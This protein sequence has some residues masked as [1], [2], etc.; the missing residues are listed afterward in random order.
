MHHQVAEAL[1]SPPRHPIPTLDEFGV[2]A[3]VDRDQSGS[4]AYRTV[5]RGDGGINWSNRHLGYLGGALA[6][7]SSPRMFVGGVFYPT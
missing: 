5:Q 6:M 7:K 1:K 2:L 3:E 4:N